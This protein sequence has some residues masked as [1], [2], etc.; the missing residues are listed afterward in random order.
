ML[1]L[2]ALVSPHSLGVRRERP[3]SVF[4]E[5]LHTTQ[6]QAGGEHGHMVNL[7]FAT[8]TIQ[9]DSDGVVDIEVSLGLVLV[10][11]IPL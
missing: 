6:I 7:F 3:R 2:T 5:A 11:F 10:G 9:Q 1:L 8:L 4:L